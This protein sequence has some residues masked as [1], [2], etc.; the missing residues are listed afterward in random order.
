MAT[1]SV[2]CVGERRLGL[3]TDYWL[4][5]NSWNSD[6]GDEDWGTFRILRG[7]DHCGIESGI[8]AGIPRK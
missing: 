2:Y 7:S 1:P 8:V 3:T 4:V 6:W 5:E